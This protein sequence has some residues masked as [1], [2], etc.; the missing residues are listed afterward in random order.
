MLGGSLLP[1]DYG[2]SGSSPSARA[3]AAS[4][5][6]G[7]DLYLFGGFQNTPFGLVDGRE[8]LIILWISCLSRTLITEMWKFDT[9]SLTWTEI[10]PPSSAEIA[11]GAVYPAARKGATAWTTS[12]TEF[13]LLL[14]SL[15]VLRCRRW[16][17]VVV[18]WRAEWARARR[19]VLLRCAARKLGCG[20]IAHVRSCTAAR[21]CLRK[22][23]RSSKRRQYN[24]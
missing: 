9:V 6:F 18:W 14:P 19:H 5:A 2:V 24:W 13:S 23:A 20:D 3:A 1:N 21:P 8:V 12:G 16:E 17:A 4:W 10:P 11:N 7:T 15:V 22:R